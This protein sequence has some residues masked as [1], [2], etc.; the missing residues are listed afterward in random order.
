MDRRIMTTN[1]HTSEPSPGSDEAI[2]QGCLCPVLD[3]A[4]GKGLGNG[5]FWI[6]S[7][8]PLHDKAT[9]EDGSK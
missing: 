4:H 7:G 5:E 1:N 3:N 2:E 9:K 6:T 8:C